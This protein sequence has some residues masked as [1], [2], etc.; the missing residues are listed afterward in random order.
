MILAALFYYI[1]KKISFLKLI[2]YTILLS[3]ICLL[4]IK[5][6]PFLNQRLM[7]AIILIENFYEYFNNNSLEIARN[8]DDSRRFF[9]TLANFNLIQYT[10]PFGTGMGLDNY[11]NYL[12]LYSS[13]FLSY[14]DHLG[15]AHNYYIS[16]LAEAGLFFFILTYLIFKPLFINSN[17]ILK[18]FYFSL[19]VGIATNEYITSPF[20]WLLLGL[21][22][23]YNSKQIKI[24]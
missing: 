23:R 7:S 22:Y 15:R 11:L 13:E 9:V 24:Q 21:V 3:L 16:Y 10:F 4:I 6:N 19:L 5:L 8:I 17:I 2:K 18:S 12:H 1:F 14:T 20:F